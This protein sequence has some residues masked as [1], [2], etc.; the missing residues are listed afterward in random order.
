MPTL[1]PRAARPSA[2]LTAVVDLPT[3]PLPEATATMRSTP[4]RARP[5]AAPALCRAAWCCGGGGAAGPDL[6]AVRLTRAVVTPGTR[7]IARSAARRRSSM[8]AASLASTRIETKTRPSLTVMPLIAPVSGNAVLP[9]G[10]TTDRSASSTSRSLAMLPL[11]DLP[12]KVKFV[13]LIQR[14]RITAPGAREPGRRHGPRH[15]LCAN[16]ARIAT[17]PSHPCLFA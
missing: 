10:P 5:R 16:A 9:S 4:G 12:T 11:Q 8:R 15:G 14:L 1:Q 2:R 13:Y 6:S 7:R 3:P 17:M